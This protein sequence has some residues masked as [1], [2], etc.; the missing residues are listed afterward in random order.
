MAVRATGSAECHATSESGRLPWEL[1]GD[2]GGAGPSASACQDL[3][4]SAR[5]G[6]RIGKDTV[7][8]LLNIGRYL[9]IPTLAEQYGVSGVVRGNIALQ[10]EQGLTVDMGL[11]AASRDQGASVDLFGFLRESTNLIAYKLYDRWGCA[12]VQCGLRAN[13][14]R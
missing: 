10:P 3:D 4:P 13:V 6:V 8:G 7:V 14:G 1:T 5:L 2:P 12:T 11:R 9:R